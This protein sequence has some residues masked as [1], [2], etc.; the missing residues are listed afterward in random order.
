MDPA[1]QLIHRMRISLGALLL[2][3]AVACSSGGGGQPVALIDDMEGLQPG[4]I[5]W[6]PPPGKAPG[7][8]FVQTDCT[9][10]DR[11]SPR[12][13]TVPGGGWSYDELPA[14]HETFPGV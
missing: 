11:I 2:A 4:A 5:P 12:P 3:G 7:S 1:N 13:W 9:E 6:A 8:W 14:P 10:N